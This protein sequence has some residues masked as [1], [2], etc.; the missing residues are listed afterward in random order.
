MSPSQWQPSAAIASLK[1][2]AE[3]LA[4]IRHFFSQ[5]D[6]LEVETPLMCQHTV[7]DVHLDPITAT[8]PTL[9]SEIP[10]YLQTS[11]EFAMKRLLAAGSGSIYQICKA[12]RA[13]DAAVKHNP[14]FTMLEWY[15][16]GFDH[17]QLIQEVDQLCQQCFG[18]P[19]AEIV[20]YRELFLQS[21]KVDLDVATEE[22]LKRVASNYLDVS[23]L[24]QMSRT[25]WFDLLM[26]ACIEPSLGQKQ[27]VVK[28]VFVVDYPK[29]QA[30]LAKVYRDQSG[31]ERAARFELFIGGIEMANGYWELTDFAEQQK[32]FSEDNE[33]RARMGRPQREL[34]K[35]FADAMAHGLPECAGVAMGID[36][37]IMA[38]ANLSNIKDTLSF[39]WDNA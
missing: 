15:R 28:P 20:S 38:A 25:D 17:W 23:G 11:P 13:D 5:A 30:A 1:Y 39:S 33:E 35:H 18:F 34:D 22:E 29:E 12:F 6:V 8:H 27:D 16:I 19:P 24:Q 2:R 3:V 10:R 31:V 14:E 21:V 26:S 36:R 9:K 7:T 37:M 4:K 32:R